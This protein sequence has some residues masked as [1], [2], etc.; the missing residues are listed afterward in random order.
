MITRSLASIKRID[1][2]EPIYT[3]I[4]NM[5]EAERICQAK[6]GGWRFIVKKGEFEVGDFAVFFEIDSILPETEW[7]EFLRDKKFRIKTLKF[8]KMLVATADGSFAPAIS[9]GL[10]LPTSILPEGTETEEDADVTEILGVT[11]YEA[12]EEFVAGDIA[13]RF[14]PFIPKT[15][16]LRV[17]S[18]PSLIA[19]LSGKPY[20]IT[21]KL[22]GSSMTA[23]W[24]EEL[25]VASR[26]FIKKN[27]EGDTFWQVARSESL[28]EKLAK[29]P[30]IAIQG[31]LVGDGVQKNRL[32]EP[33]RRMYVFNVFDIETQRYYNYEEMIEF[34]SKAG[35][36]TVPVIES[37]DS[38]AY[39]MENLDAMVQKMV[40]PLSKHPAE[41]I[42][43]RSA[44]N[45]YS[46]TIQGRLSFKY[47]NPV[48]LLKIGE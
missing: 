35:L 5:V 20:Y 7:S 15:D 44:Q 10:A 22:D 21:M 11:K 27:E 41:G 48:F 1:A 29:Y 38:F 25:Q 23:W 18:Y 37:G 16:E 32:G 9:Q 33:K 47:I 12:P 46:Q 36:E 24:D 19:E 45:T 31:E 4:I 34:C 40:Y 2:I 6:I 17:Q 42:V 26:N 14:P 13:G 28:E 30:K 39:S 3:D 8:N 43:I